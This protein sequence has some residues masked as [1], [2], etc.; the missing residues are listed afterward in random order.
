VGLVSE[1][2]FQS[3]NVRATRTLAELAIEAGVKQFVFTSTTALY[4]SASTPGLTAAWVD[5]G[6]EP[7]ARTIH[8][9]TKLA[10]EVLLEAISLARALAVTVLRMSRCFPERAPIMASYRLHR[11]S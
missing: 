6:L 4:G 8:H 11:G 10:A 1:I 2:D 5:E 9:R 3:V 7:Q